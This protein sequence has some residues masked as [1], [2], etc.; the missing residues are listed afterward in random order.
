MGNGFPSYQCNLEKTQ[1]Q[2][3][4]GQIMACTLN[5][6][7]QPMLTNFL[8]EPFPQMSS[9]KSTALCGRG[10][11]VVS[12]NSAETNKIWNS[13]YG[14]V[15]RM[16]MNTTMN[17]KRESAEIRSWSTRV[18]AGQISEDHQGGKP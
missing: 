14:S 1:L 2:K 7:V 3:Q 13:Q 9:R 4:A 5:I 18:S 16:K 17:T 15:K 6:P 10:I 12:R 11:E 8:A